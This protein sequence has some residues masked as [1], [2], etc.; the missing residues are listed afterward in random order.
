M[1]TKRINLN[2]L[3]DNEFLYLRRKDS[4]FWSD[5]KNY[6][7]FQNLHIYFSLI[8]IWLWFKDV[9]LKLKI[10][11]VGCQPKSNFD[12]RIRYFGFGQF[13][14]YFLLTLTFLN[15]ITK[16]FNNG[17]IKEIKVKSIQINYWN[18]YKSQ[19]LFFN[20][21]NILIYS[22]NGISP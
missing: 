14:Q 21:F 22:R 7:N 19:F 13:Q 15:P 2:F 3:N 4:K 9:D 10:C 20:P 6:K 11:G 5:H 1:D 12:L 8:D 18:I 17:R 16:E